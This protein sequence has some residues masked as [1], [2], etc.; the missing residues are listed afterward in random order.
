MGVGCVVADQQD[1]PVDQGPEAEPSTGE[2]LREPQADVAYVEPPD[3]E[4][5]EEVKPR[6]VKK[7]TPRKTRGRKAS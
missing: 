1:D 6:P 5:A 7:A 2:E 3:T 4:G